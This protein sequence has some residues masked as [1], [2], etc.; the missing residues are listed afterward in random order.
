MDETQM[1][2]AK[3]KISFFH[4][5]FDDGTFSIRAKSPLL[6]EYVLPNF[7]TIHEGYLRLTNQVPD[8]DAEE[9][10]DIDN[11]GVGN[12]D[13]EGKNNGSNS[14]GQGAGIDKDRI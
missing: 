6:G 8:P 5:I 9:E 13:D 7:K 4:Q 12:E 2:Q 1:N 3:E 11:K 10:M 14:G